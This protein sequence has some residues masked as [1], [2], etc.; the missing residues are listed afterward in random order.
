[1]NSKDTRSIPQGLLPF[2]HANVRDDNI[3]WQFI[4]GNYLR[5]FQYEYDW[6]LD[7][8]AVSWLVRKIKKKKKSPLYGRVRNRPY[9]LS[10]NFTTKL[11]CDKVVLSANRMKLKGRRK[12]RE[13]LSQKTIGNWTENKYTC[14]YMKRRFL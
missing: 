7:E 11:L 9:E 5:I 8:Q 10:F 13:I 4:K 2:L 12:L 1:M 14:M 6:F 3:R